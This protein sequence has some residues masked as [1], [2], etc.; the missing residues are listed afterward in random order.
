M[1]LLTARAAAARAAAVSAAALMLLACSQPAA[2]NAAAGAANT[3]S[4][5]T[6]TSAPAANQAAAPAVAR[7][8]DGQL[9]A[10]I[11][12]NQLPQ[13]R[14]GLWRST[15]SEDGGPPRQDQQCH[16]GRPQDLELGEGCAPSIHRTLTGGYQI[17]AT[18]DA[19]GMQVRMNMHAEGNFTSEYTVD[20]EYS[21]TR[22]GQTTTHRGHSVARYAGPCPAGEEE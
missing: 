3:A 14:A 2:N 9:G 15:E 12:A 22:N 18:C 16:N 1:F 20:T 11:P 5:A 21:M 13:P 8:P 10:V 4:T 6:G 19:N 17:S 7:V